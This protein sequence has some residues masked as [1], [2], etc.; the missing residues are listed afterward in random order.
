MTGD[1][2]FVNA[3][4]PVWGIQRGMT[5]LNV[6]DPAD[7]EGRGCCIHHPSQHHMVSWPQ[8]WRADRRMMERICPCGVG[9]PDPDDLN[10][11]DV[12]GC[13]GCCARPREAA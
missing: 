7:C 9:H 11:D 8:N 6:H 10:S 13:C 4:E 2:I 1:Y 3:T 12:H 5:L